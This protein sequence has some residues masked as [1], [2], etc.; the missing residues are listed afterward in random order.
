M[1]LFVSHSWDDKPLVRQ[2]VE[3]PKFITVWLDESRLAAGDELDPV[4]K[5]AIEDSHL[6]L[7]M[8][9]QTALAKDWVAKELLWAQ[10]CAKRFYVERTFVVPI[11]IDSN[12]DF[13]ACAAPY[14][15]LA[16]TLYIDASDTSDSGVEHSRHRIQETLLEWCSE[17]V[18]EYE[19]I[20]S[21]DRLFAEKV[22]KDLTQFQ[23][24]LFRI[25]ATLSNPLHALVKPDARKHL[26]E[27]K[28]KYNEFTR[29]FIPEL[30][31]MDDVIR[32][33]FDRSHR[34]FERLSEFVR[35]DVYRGAAF[36]LNDIVEAINAYESDL[37]DNP[38]EYDKAEATRQQ[39]IDDLEHILEK[40]QIESRYFLDSIKK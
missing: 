39:K 16:N 22:E 4:I 6:F 38:D 19:P 8:I 23:D 7:L 34:S 31:R 13:K 32:W 11:I 35:E 1:Q 15:S 36:A 30:T 20:G 17:R 5:N 24:H 18:L 12:I 29:Y 3:L 25:K 26:R 2:L 27:A 40:L 10:Q 21:S 9:S 33:R 37:R 14:D 28:E